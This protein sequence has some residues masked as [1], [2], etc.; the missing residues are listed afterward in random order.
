MSLL[1]RPA[2]AGVT[3]WGRLLKTPGN[4]YSGLELLLGESRETQRVSMCAANPTIVVTKNGEISPPA[5][6]L[7]MYYARSAVAPLQWHHYSSTPLVVGANECRHRT[8]T[9]VG[10]PSAPAGPPSVHL[11]P[12]MAFFPLPS[13]FSHRLSQL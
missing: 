5:V 13:L 11:Y 6:G 1:S 9:P 4:F 10:P 12:S 8:A 7:A 3:K 2:F